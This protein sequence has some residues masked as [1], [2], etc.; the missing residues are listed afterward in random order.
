MF[1][2]FWMN[3]LLPPS[4]TTFARKIHHLPARRFSSHALCAEHALLFF[5]YR[6][7]YCLAVSDASMVLFSTQRLPSKSFPHTIP[8][9]SSVSSRNLCGG[10]FCYGLHGPWRRGEFLMT[11]TGA[12]TLQQCR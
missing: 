5:V 7:T 9:S 2:T 6:L 10:C 8:S 1:R 4:T 11:A 12:E 3:Q